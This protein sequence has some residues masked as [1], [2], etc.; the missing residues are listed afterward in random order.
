MEFA[1]IEAKEVE[2]VAS[3]TEAAQVAE[4]EEFQLALVGGGCV[5]VIVG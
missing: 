2:K 4:L 1:N 5:T 3:A